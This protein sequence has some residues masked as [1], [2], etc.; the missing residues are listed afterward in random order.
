MPKFP[1]KYKLKSKLFLMK[2]I[3]IVCLQRQLEIEEK[4]VILIEMECE[5]R[6][7]LWQCHL[8][9]LLL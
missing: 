3:E 5:N 1:N 4:E 9:K 6:N 7:I 2:N 8:S